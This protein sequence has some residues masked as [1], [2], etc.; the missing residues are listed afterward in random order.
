MS[1]YRFK[2]EEEFKAEGLWDVKTNRPIN[3]SE[4]MI[5]ALGQSIDDECIE[6]IESERFFMP[7]TP[8]L[9]IY[10]SKRDTILM[11]EQLLPI[12]TKVFIATKSEHYNQ[13]I[14]SDGSNKI[15]KIIEPTS[16]RYDYH[17]YIY[18]VQW[19]DNPR[20][21]NTYKPCDLEPIKEKNEEEINNELKQL[22]KQI[23]NN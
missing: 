7:D 17:R 20:D 13:G 21:E 19:N 22:F 8:P 9:Y 3:W 10:E 18:L 15:G 11:E 6:R 1:K 4:P 23:L 12:G 14:N 5:Y 16:S 2:T